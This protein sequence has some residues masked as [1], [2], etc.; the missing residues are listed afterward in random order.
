MCK[1]VFQS[2]LEFIIHQAIYNDQEDVSSGNI[3][4]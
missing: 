2:K 1:P 3:K 4:V